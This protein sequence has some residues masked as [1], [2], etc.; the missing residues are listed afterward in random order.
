MIDAVEA[1]ATDVPGV[2]GGIVFDSYGGAINQVAAADTAF[3]HRDAIAC[4]QYSVTY[5][6]ASPSPSI[7][8]AA[9]AWLEQ[10]QSSFA[11]YRHAAPIRTTSIRRCPTGPRPTTGRTC[12]RLM[13]VKRA[14][15]PDDLFHFAQSVPLPT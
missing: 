2:G 11:P 1:L 4:A 8:A 7:V 13:E 5:G 9:Q 14:Y 15:D 10:T 12:P 6:S 3:V